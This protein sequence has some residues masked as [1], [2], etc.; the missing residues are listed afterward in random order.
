M[1]VGAIVSRKKPYG[2][3]CLGEVQASSVLGAV[4]AGAGCAGA[5]GRGQPRLPLRALLGAGCGS[6]AGE[7]QEQSMAFQA[8]ELSIQLIEVLSPLMP[9]IKQRDRSLADQL[10][11][12]ASSIALNLGEAELSDP[13]NRKARLFSAAGSANETLTALRVAV[14]WR[15]LQAGHAEAAMG[16]AKRIV[17]IL[18]RMTRG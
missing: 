11:R 8:A 9:R 13:G 10:S 12:A 1:I 15:H 16:L 4:E 18:W 17:A 2:L 14:A 3:A 5:R 6:Q 7:A